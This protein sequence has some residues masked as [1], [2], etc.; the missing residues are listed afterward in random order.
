M[1]NIIIRKKRHWLRKIIENSFL[2]FM[3]SIVLGIL[4]ILL[5]FLCHIDNDNLTILYL[6]FS[7]STK[8]FHSY[9]RMFTW[10]ISLLLT[11]GFFIQMYRG[12]KEND[13]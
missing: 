9:F 7:I 2:L 6:L 10:V 8:E 3:W 11:I 12:S 1:K 5:C 13:I 4:F